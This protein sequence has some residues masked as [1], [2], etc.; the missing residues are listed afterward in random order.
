LINIDDFFDAFSAR[1]GD[2]YLFAIG[3]YNMEGGDDLFCMVRSKK[4][5]RI[6]A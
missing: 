4:R 2:D 5:L 1:F 6:A 3:H